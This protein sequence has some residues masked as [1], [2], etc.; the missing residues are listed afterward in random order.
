[1]VGKRDEHITLNMPIQQV[2]QLIEEQALHVKLPQPLLQR[3]RDMGYNLDDL[4]DKGLVR[5]DLVVPCLHE[6]PQYDC[7]DG[8]EL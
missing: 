7:Y 6:V 8:V 4:C 2:G 1:M 5:R 3:S